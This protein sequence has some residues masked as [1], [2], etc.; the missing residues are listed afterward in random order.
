MQQLID[1]IKQQLN[2]DIPLPFSVYTS[3]KEQRILNVPVINPLLICVLD[4]CKKLGTDDSINCPSGD[5]VFLSNNPHIDMRNIPVDKEYF[6]LLI[7]F[8]E[9]DFNAFT[10]QISPKKKFIQGQINHSFE[11]S[12]I[13]FVE[14]CS[15]APQD[16]WSLRKQEILHLLYHQGYHNIAGISTPLS[17]SHKLYN[18]LRSKLDYNFTLQKLA[19][20]MAMSESTLRRKLSN[21]GNTVQSIKDNVRL[22]HGLHLLQTTNTPIGLIAHEC[23][24]LS[25]SRFTDKFKQ[26]FGLTPSGLR[27]TQLNK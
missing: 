19:D 1:S 23:G 6:A 15:F 12:L 25:Q 14:W 27:K 2:K 20:V 7:E 10:T 26:L 8:E 18:L 16:M 17:I 5:F 22:S 21:E 11:N 9:Q 4:G 24:Y 3:I 13:Q